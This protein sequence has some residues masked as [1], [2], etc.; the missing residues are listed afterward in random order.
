[1]S[2]M[3]LSSNTLVLTLIPRYLLFEVRSYNQTRTSSARFKRQLTSAAST[4]KWSASSANLRTAD[5]LEDHL[6]RITRLL[7]PALP[8]TAAGPAS[9]GEEYRG[10]PD[11][12]DAATQIAPP[13]VDLP[14]EVR[15]R[16]G[17]TPPLRHNRAIALLPRAD[18][19]PGLMNN[20]GA[21]PSS[22]TRASAPHN[23]RARVIGHLS[24]PGWL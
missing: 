11:S 9:A 5:R 22:R 8:S 21:E 6:S 12:V 2:R 16:H 19:L 1:M 17:V 4:S 10:S 24:P 15:P 20:R 3:V 23:D 14:G 7:K 13:Q 18:S